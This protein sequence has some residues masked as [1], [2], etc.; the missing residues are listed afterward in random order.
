M[1]RPD[2]GGID[3]MKSSRRRF[4]S[5]LFPERRDRAVAV[6]SALMV[7]VAMLWLVA[8]S[9]AANIPAPYT[10]SLTTK[11]QMVD[12][13]ITEHASSIISAQVWVIVGM[14]GMLQT[15]FGFIVVYVLKDIKGNIAS[16]FAMAGKK[17]DKDD[18]VR[19]ESRLRT[20]R[21]I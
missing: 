11:G 1:S 15:L 19:C 9:V 7:I 3:R 5:I 2:L 10:H 20:Q 16:L 8:A 6:S 21:R 4:M 12:I 14:F 17:V 13:P 18:C